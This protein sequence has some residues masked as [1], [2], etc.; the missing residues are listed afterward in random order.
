MRKLKLHVAI[1]IDGCIAGPNNEMDWIDFTWNEKLREYEDRLH[2]SVDTI[3]LERK[4]T[5]EFIFVST[6]DFTMHVNGNNPSP[7]DF[8]GSESATSVSIAPGP[9]AVTKTKPTLSCSQGFKAIFSKD[10]IGEINDGVTK[11][12]IVTNKFHT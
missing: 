10:C 12:C 7:F 5:N 9:Y 4:M 11:T 3:P 6:S 1:S 8:P 2:E